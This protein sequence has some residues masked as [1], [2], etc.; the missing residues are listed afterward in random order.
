MNKFV[1]LKEENKIKSIQWFYEEDNNEN[2]FD[3][4]LMNILININEFVFLDLQS[5][6]NKL[7]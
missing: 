1:K 6:S 2:S 3:D 4:Y 5:L 7:N